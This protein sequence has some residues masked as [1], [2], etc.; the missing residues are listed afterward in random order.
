[1]RAPFKRQVKPIGAK[2]LRNGDGSSSSSSHVP[3]WSSSTE[4]D[5][6]SLDPKITPAN[7]MVVT[8]G[9]NKGDK[10]IQKEGIGARQVQSNECINTTELPINQANNELVIIDNKRRRTGDGLDCINMGLTEEVPM[11]SDGAIELGYE[12]TDNN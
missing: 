9:G 1:M 6:G 12:N 3:G 8:R 5:E 4:E 2:W 10:I 7:L 11:D